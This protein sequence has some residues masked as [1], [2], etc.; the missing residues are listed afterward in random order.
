MSSGTTPT[1]LCR[2]PVFLAASIPMAPNTFSINGPQHLPPINQALV[3]AAECAVVYD[4]PY[5][6]A[7]SALTWAALAMR[8]III[9]TFTGATA[10]FFTAN[11]RPALLEAIKQTSYH[12]SF[13]YSEANSP[14]KGSANANGRTAEDWCGASRHMSLVDGGTISQPLKR[15]E[16]TPSPTTKRDY[17]TCLV[18][19]RWWGSGVAR[20]IFPGHIN[21]SS[22]FPAPACL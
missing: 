21:I 7:V 12:L 10:P 16:T 14:L 6:K 13:L 2:N 11:T 18:S 5:C 4:V 17:I 20:M 19:V 9:I 22:G 15:Q 8:P 1:W 3:S